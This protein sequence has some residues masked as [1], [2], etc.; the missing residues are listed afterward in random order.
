MDTVPSSR[1]AINDPNQCRLCMRVCEDSFLEHIFSDKEYS[2]AHQ[3]FE[4]TSIRVTKQDNLTKICKN[5]AS[6]LFLTTEFRNACF[7]TNRLLMEDFV[8]MELGDWASDANR[9]LLRD[10]ESFIVRHRE[11]VDYVYASIVTDSDPCLD[12]TLELDTELFGP[13]ERDPPAQ[14]NTGDREL[15]RSGPEAVEPLVPEEPDPEILMEISKFLEEQVPDPEPANCYGHEPTETGCFL[16]RSMSEQGSAL[17]ETQLDTLRLH[18]LTVPS[19]ALVGCFVCEHCCLLLDIV[20][21]FRQM[22]VIAQSTVR[23]GAVVRVKPSI[24]GLPGHAK[25]LLQVMKQKHE[26]YTRHESTGEPATM[27]DNREPADPSSP[28]E[29]RPSERSSEPDVRPYVCDQAGCTSAF[30]GLVFLNRHKKL[31]HTDYYY[32]VCGVCGKQCKTQGIYQTH[33]S[34][35]EEP[36]LP[37]TICGKLMRNKRAIWKHMKTHSND[38]KHVCTVCNKRFTIAYTLRVHMRIHTNEK[39]Y[40]CGQCDKRFQYKCLLKTHHRKHHEEVLRME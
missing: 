32:A 15:V 14:R 24:E 21:S 25:A 31:W 6:L 4:C 23:Q 36:K 27:T 29:K 3:I 8:I 37:C 28:I 40:P 16:C 20:D 5:C 9:L 1:S 12:G 2:I 39:P 35:H 17:T 13:T 10:C 18:K 7:K 22:F 19:G 34:Y 38:R 33:L 30:T 11:Q 26:A